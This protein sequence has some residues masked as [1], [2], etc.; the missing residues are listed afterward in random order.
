MRATH[1]ES[2][3]ASRLELSNTDASDLA[4]RIEA[5][6]S[7]LAAIRIVLLTDGILLGSLAEAGSWKARVVEYDGED[8]ARADI[9]A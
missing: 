6:A 8:E 3:L 2:Y 5:E 1:H 4:R 9:A 7:S